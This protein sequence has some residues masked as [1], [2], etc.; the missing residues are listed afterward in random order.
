MMKKCFFAAAI[1]FALS[2][3]AQAQKIAIVDVNQI[4]NTL[5]DYKRA[6]EDL[7]KIAQTWRS[8]IAKQQ[9][10]IK[11]LYNRYQAEQVLLNDDARR[12]REDEITN[13]EKEV[14]EAQRAKFGPE[15]D[16]F[17]KRQ[18]LVKPIQDKVYG[19]IEK[20]ANERGYDLIL[21]KSSS[22]GLIFANATYDKTSQLLD[23]IKKM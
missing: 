9:D 12:Q 5:P 8:D 20:F 6:Q 17:R 15:G 22:A 21:D 18:E 19:A 23:I 14:R 3:S 11:G 13:K 1:L 7:E 4:L 2:F 10:V 16:L